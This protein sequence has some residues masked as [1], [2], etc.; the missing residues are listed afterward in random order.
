[1]KEARRFYRGGG[2]EL[3]VNFCGKLGVKNMVH[4]EV[5]SE[6]FTFVIVTSQNVMG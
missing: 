4:W 6:G 3:T 5:H 1:M 2:K